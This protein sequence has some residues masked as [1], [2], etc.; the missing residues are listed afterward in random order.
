MAFQN[1][2][3]RLI[4]FLFG[5]AID[6]VLIC[7]RRDG[8]Q[9][10]NTV[11]IVVQLHFR[12]WEHYVLDW[13]GRDGLSWASSGWA[14]RRRLYPHSFIANVGTFWVSSTFF[15]L[16]T[17]RFSPNNKPATLNS[18][19]A[20][21]PFLPPRWPYTCMPFCPLSHA[22]ACATVWEHLS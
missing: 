5:M 6:P 14:E 18:N 20:S 12:E 9:L 11:R 4:Y 2:R 1:G 21:L 7:T 17:G 15:E 3:L 13:S 16:P 22:R 19:L 10:R 8:P